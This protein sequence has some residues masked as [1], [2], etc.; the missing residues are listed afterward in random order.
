MRRSKMTPKRITVNS[1]T[2]PANSRSARLRGWNPSSHSQRLSD[3]PPMPPAKNECPDPH[4][5]ERV[6]PPGSAL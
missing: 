3:T 5:S 2:L 6:N 4:G 1:L